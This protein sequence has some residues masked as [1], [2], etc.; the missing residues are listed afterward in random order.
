M[1]MCSGAKSEQARSSY[2]GLFLCVYIVIRI[3]F[4]IY[5]LNNVMYMLQ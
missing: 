2:D 1:P 4:V 5:T 3:Y